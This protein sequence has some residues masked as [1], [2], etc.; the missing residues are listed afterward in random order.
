[1]SL[2]SVVLFVASLSKTCGVTVKYAMQHSI[3]VQIVKLDTT[4]ARNRAAN[5]RYFQVKMVP[6]MI[7]NYDD[8]NM[9]VFIGNDKIL[10]VLSSLSRI[11]TQKANE[12]MTPL[13]MGDRSNMYGPSVDGPSMRPSK[14][15]YAARP[16]ISRGNIPIIEHDSDSDESNGRVEPSIE[17]SDEEEIPELERPAAKAKTKAKAKIS[18]TKSKSK[19][20]KK[21]PPIIFTE[22]EDDQDREIEVEYIDEAS[23]VQ[24]QEETTRGGASSKKMKNSRMQGLID[25][26]KNME[27]E[28]LASLGYNEADLPHYH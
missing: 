27:Q 24:V 28:R 12:S 16:T 4:E 9:E 2:S 17:Y 26:A 7:V 25:T 22:D 14:P 18:K 13:D 20:K 15:V 10:P 11:K 19:S 6:T 1:M 5:G 23:S 3:P 21:K 8:G